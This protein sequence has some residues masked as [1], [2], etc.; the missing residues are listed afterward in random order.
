MGLHL[1]QEPDY[2][3]SLYVDELIG[4]DTVNTLPEST[5]EAFEQHG[6]V[7]RTIDERLD[8]ARDTL[9]RLETVG[10]DLADVGDTLER[11][12]V[13]V[14]SKSFDDVLASL[15][16]KRAALTGS[17]VRTGRA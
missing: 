1:D 16:A 8:Q 9:R 4:P 14:F 12:G 15:D 6:S 3:K 7:A 11:D 13:A 10:V 2:P 17:P 5:I